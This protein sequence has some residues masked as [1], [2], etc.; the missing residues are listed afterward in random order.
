VVVV[1]QANR[2]TVRSDVDIILCDMFAHIGGE[3]ADPTDM[4]GR[5]PKVVVFTWSVP[6]GAG[7][8]AADG[9]AGYLSKGLS[10]VELVEALEAIHCGGPVPS[11]D[12]EDHAVGA[13]DWPG[14][15][16]GL[17]PR[18][19]EILALIVR[20]LS[21]QEIAEAIFLSINSV[22]TYIRTAYRKIGVTRRQLAV[23]WALQHGF[24]AEIRRAPVHPNSVSWARE[25]GLP[26]E[27]GECRSNTHPS[28]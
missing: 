1:E 28:E 18:E 6:P 21:N 16:A 19:A 8:G 4:L 11:P 7:P 27:K 14:R 5:G 25:T 23:I 24:T 17:T 9:V 2:R 20:G 26:P 3:G 12:V 15:E 22:K 10:A 13:G